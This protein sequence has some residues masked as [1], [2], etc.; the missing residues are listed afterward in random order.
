MKTLVTIMI[1]G[2]I[3][4]S[5]C[6]AQSNSGKISGRVFDQGTGKT[7]SKEIV[8]LYSGDKQ[9]MSARTNQSGNFSFISLD[10]GEYALKIQ[11]NGYI[12]FSRKVRV[13]ANFT[14]KI[15]VSLK[16]VANETKPAQVLAAETQS[17]NTQQLVKNEPKP[18][19]APVQMASLQKQESANLQNSVSNEL[20]TPVLDTEDFV[21]YP[22]EEISANTEFEYYEAVEDQP[23]P[24][25][26]WK[27]L[28][29]NVV[30][31]QDAVKMNMQGTVYLQAWISEQGDVTSLK[32][33]KSIPM[34]DLAAQEA[35]YK[36][37]FI[38]GKIGGNAVASI[39]TIPVAFRISK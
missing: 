35:V 20:Q 25:D 33:Q 2:F 39:L 9:T 18:D 24:S 12:S 23:V 31:P 22:T 5:I 29:K 6:S 37:K 13:N 26:G 3:L 11:R 4:T 30:Y 10:P 32:V 21:I 27:S 15:D 38:P 17:Q 28:M 19:S 7:V 34:L 16:P 36:T 8:L 1:S 14:S